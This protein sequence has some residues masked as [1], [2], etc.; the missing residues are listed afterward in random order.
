M[1]VES[2][3]KAIS[4]KILQ[5]FSVKGKKILR[6][7]GGKPAWNLGHMGDGAGGR[8]SMEARKARLGTGG[9]LGGKL[10]ELRGEHTT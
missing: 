8:K 1:T 4:F 10:P 7:D 5:N 2:L 3:W 6:S 9:T